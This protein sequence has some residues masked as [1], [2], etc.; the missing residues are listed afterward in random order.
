MATSHLMLIFVDKS[1]GFINV[2][3]QDPLRYKNKYSCK[4][5]HSLDAQID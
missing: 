1:A 3:L 4:C 5:A 2:S